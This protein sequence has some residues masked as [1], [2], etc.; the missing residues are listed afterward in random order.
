LKRAS[1][2][3]RRSSGGAGAAGVGGLEQHPVPQH[4]D[5]HVLARPP[6]ADPVE[7][8]RDIVGGRRPG[9]RP[10]DLDGVDA[11]DR[12]GVQQL[13][14]D[15]PLAERRDRGAFPLAGG[16]GLP[17][18]LAEERPDRRR[19]QRGDVTVVVGGERDQ[20]A[21]VGADRIARLVRVR[22]VG[23][24]VVDVAGERVPRQDV[25]GGLF[26]ARA[27]SCLITGNQSRPTW[28]CSRR[29]HL[30]MVGDVA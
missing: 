11:V 20:V 8:R 17:G 13:V 12:A 15:G 2:S 3:S 4:V 1:Y 16:R 5:R 28:W 27:R 21:A 26:Q 9:Q 18:D 14:P 19:G 7:H 22:Q 23:E 10:G 30:A 24:E 29:W 25:A 6:G